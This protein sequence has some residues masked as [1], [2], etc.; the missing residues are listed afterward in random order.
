[1]LEKLK[2]FIINT[3]E[4]GKI[5]TIRPYQDRSYLYIEDVLLDLGFEKENE[6]FYDFIIDNI[7]VYSFNNKSYVVCDYSHFNTNILSVTII[8]SEFYDEYIINKI[9]EEYKQ[10]LI[11]KEM[12]LLDL[13]INY[14][15]GD[16]IFD[17]P[18]DSIR[19]SFVFKRY[20]KLPILIEY[21][22]V[23]DSDNI[24]NVVIRITNVCKF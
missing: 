23:E 5:V 13:D 11:G 19:E 10:E 14:I 7:S 6:Q 24:D 2:D 21:D 20:E 16:S 1:M 12:T 4:N 18:E 8:E 22:I 17:Y 3:E 15:L 9:V